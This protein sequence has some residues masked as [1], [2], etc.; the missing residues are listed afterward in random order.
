MRSPG[1]AASSCASVLNSPLPL[2]TTSFGRAGAGGV[3]GIGSG[4]TASGLAGDGDTHR[5]AD[6]QAD[7]T[8]LENQGYDGVVP[9]RERVGGRAD[10]VLKHPAQRV[11]SAYV[12]DDRLP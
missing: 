11:G 6:H 12:L 3:S 8:K 2:S 4:S 10:D 5:K 7:E 9:G 1:A